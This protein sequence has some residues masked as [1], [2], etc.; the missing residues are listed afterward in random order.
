MFVCYLLI[1]DDDLEF[2]TKQAV[3][4]LSFLIALIVVHMLPVADWAVVVAHLFLTIAVG[5]FI[6]VRWRKQ[7]STE[8]GPLWQ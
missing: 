5:I 1:P 2:Y 8:V 3:S 4:V 6:A 7:S